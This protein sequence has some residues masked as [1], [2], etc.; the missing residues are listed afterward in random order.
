MAEHTRAIRGT[1]AARA[2][3][4]QDAGPAGIVAACAAMPDNACATASADGDSAGNTEYT[5]RAE[6]TSGT[7]HKSAESDDADSAAVSDAL[8]AVEVAIGGL[9]ITSY[10]LGRRL[11]DEIPDEVARRTRFLSY[12]Y[13]SVRGT[14]GSARF[15]IV[16]ACHPVLRLSLVNIR[17]HGRI[18]RGPGL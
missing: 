7:V 15:D 14:R 2:A 5:G 8:N 12:Q 18:C 3:E 11:E 9:R 10:A 17:E 1:A 6:V 4:T 13:G 16:T